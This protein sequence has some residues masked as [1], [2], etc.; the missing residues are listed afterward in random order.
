MSYTDYIWDLGGTLLDNYQT[1]AKAF[2][3]VLMYDFGIKASFDDIHKALRISTAVAIDKFASDLP[4]F[5]ELYK[6]REV[7]DLSQPVLFPGAGDVLA[8]IVKDGKRNFMISHRDDHVLDILE[9]AGIAHYFTEVVTANN[10]FERKPSPDSIN[11]LL[12]K[13][14]LKHAVMIGDREIDML[15]GQHANIDTIYFNSDDQPEVSAT[16]KINQLIAILKL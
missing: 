6:K 16:H 3:H 7:Q 2:Q 11:Y 8:A 5:K 1:S 4:R 13:Y 14:H 9:A 15:A 10:G 12:N